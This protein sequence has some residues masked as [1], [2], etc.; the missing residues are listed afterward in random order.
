MRN[1]TAKQNRRKTSFPRYRIMYSDG[2]KIIE[3]KCWEL[4]DALTQ[5]EALRRSHDKEAQLYLI[6]S[7]GAESIYFKGDFISVGAW[8]RATQL[9]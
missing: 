1:R 2:R 3:R 8:F 7:D 4:D 5:L 6:S 9:M